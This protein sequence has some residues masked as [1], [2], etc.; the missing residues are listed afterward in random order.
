MHPLR[1]KVAPVA[2]VMAAL[3]T[4]WLLLKSPPDAP[5]IPASFRNA[6]LE[7]HDSDDK[8]YDDLVK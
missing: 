6:M 7:L 4:L 1:V 5:S 2:M 8:P 3:L